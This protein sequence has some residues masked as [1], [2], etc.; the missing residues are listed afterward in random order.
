MGESNSLMKMDHSP[1]CYETSGKT[2][3]YAVITIK[4]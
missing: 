1:P 3:I 4:Y 2:Q